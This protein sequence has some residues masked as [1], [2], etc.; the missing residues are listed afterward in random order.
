MNPWI[1][2]ADKLPEHGQEVICVCDWGV[3]SAEC[4][5]GFDNEL[6]FGNV[7]PGCFD[8]PNVTYWMP[9]PAQPT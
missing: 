2:V 7:R 5:I 1:A 9:K 6:H 4:Y 8:C 3:S